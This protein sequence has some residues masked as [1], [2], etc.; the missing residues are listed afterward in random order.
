MTTVPGPARPAVPPPRPAAPAPPAEASAG[1][2]LR[3]LLD[4]A[5]IQQVLQSLAEV[6]TADLV[7]EGVEGVELVRAAAAPGRAAVKATGQASRL[8]VTD[9][10]TGELFGHLTVI[11]RAARRI[12]ALR[13]IRLVVGF[14]GQIIA[15]EREARQRLAELTAV[16]NT[17]MMLAEARDLGN[18]LSR[19]VRLVADVM[20]VKGASIRLIDEPRDELRIAAAFGLSE[21]YVKKGAL[22]LSRAGIDHAALTKGHEQVLDL[23]QDDRV[24]F[25]ELLETERL[26]SMLSVPMRYKAQAVGVLRAYTDRPHRFG[27]AEVG[28]MRAVASQA[29]AA[30]VN[31]RLAEETAEAEALERQVLLAADVQQRMVPIAAPRCRHLEFASAYIPCFELAGDLFDFI[32]LGPDTVGVVIAD[33]VGKG[34]PASLIMATVRAYL[35]A[36]SEHLDD[37]AEAV[38]RLNVMLCRDNRPG[39]FVSLFYGVF[40]GAARTLDYVL[41]G[42]VPPLL[43]RGGRIE[44]VATGDMVLGV[45]PDAPFTARRLELRPDDRLLLY[46]DGLDEARNFHEELYG[47]ARV[48]RS[49]A[50]PADDAEMMVQNVVWDMRRFVGLRRKTDDVTVIAVRVLGA[51]PPTGG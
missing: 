46:T 31:T 39:E 20:G 42:H 2:D 12:D 11:P 38:R 47:H 9:P 23:R 34:V 30:I 29:A 45:V 13:L 5:R 21:A 36:T 37:P 10:T 43:Q 32:P 25:P 18:L 40:D 48:K 49:L 41:A 51:D 14:L 27:N 26:V 50:Q 22:R 16:Y 7:L 35:R 44:Q 15:H 3:E 28:L 24:Q 6:A 1:E 4:L 19:T 8:P 33:V 17:S